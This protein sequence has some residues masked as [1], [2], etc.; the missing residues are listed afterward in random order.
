MSI[1][2][3]SI[4]Q[5]FPIFKIKM[6]GKPLTYLDSTATSQRPNQVIDAVDAYY[7]EYNANIHRGIYQISERAS[8]AYDESK[9]KVAKF[10][11]AESMQ[12][13]IYL[14]NAT[15]ALNL[16]ALAWGDA[17]ISKGDHILISEMEHHSNIVPW[18]VLAKKKEAVLDYIKLDAK[19]AKLDMGSLKEQLE[20]RPKI[21]SVTH[22][23]NVLGTI[24]NVREITKMAHGKGAV[25]LIDGAQSAPHMEV[26]VGDIDCD[27]YAFSGH[28][29]LAPT[30]IGVLYGKEAILDKMEPL[31][32]GGEMI[33]SVEHHAY[34]WND[35]PW[36]F[37]A[38]TSN[39][40]GG[41]GL[42]AAVDYL[43]S[44]GMHNVREHEKQI[45]RYALEKL[46]KI[47]GVTVYGP[48]INDMDERGGVISF[49]IE[50]IHPHDVSQI[51]DSE[52]IAIRSGH[53]CA[54]P[55]VTKTLAQP[56]LSRMS[57]YIYNNESDVDKAIEAI[58]KAKKIFKIA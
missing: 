7:K 34:S 46:S 45:T 5:D 39:I 11:N 53:H 43:S 40:S 18:I 31:L 25:V 55:L 1:E 29:M 33:K 26:D 16:V 36:K 28:K 20:K 24:N 49:A 6:N 22:A 12:E 14:R 51:F 10:I 58:N 54:M 19:K 56:A 17:N 47:N 37:E 42:G 30:G 35:L 23:S 21:V 57:F 3:N 41:I 13:I 32:T 4:K 52:G 9:R 48:D 2:A 15:E 44:L 50:G 8:E 38:G 27:F